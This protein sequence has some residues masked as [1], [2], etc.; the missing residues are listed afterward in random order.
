M[1]DKHTVILTL[2]MLARIKHQDFF[3]LYKK[4]KKLI[5]LPYAEPKV[6]IPNLF[7]PE[8]CRIRRI[9]CSKL[10]FNDPT[11]DIFYTVPPRVK[12]TKRKGLSKYMRAPE[13]K[14]L[15]NGMLNKKIKEVQKSYSMN[16]STTIL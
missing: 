2:D 1:G 7:S 10:E 12:N 11:E 9:V 16:G 14:E 3:K 15:K 5:K 4:V 6:I 8:P 13:E